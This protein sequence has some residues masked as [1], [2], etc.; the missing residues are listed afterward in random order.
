MT[1]ARPS[2]SAQNVALVRALLT[3]AGV[4]DD[5]YARQMLSPDRRRKAALFQLPGVRFRLPG[6]PGLAARTRFFDSF[7]DEALDGGV[8]QVVIVG[9]GYDSRAWR[10]ARPG[11]TFYE[12]DRPATQ[13]DKRAKAPAG[14]PVY[15]P[16]DVTDPHLSEA[17]RRA[18][19]QADRPTAFVLEGLI[20]YLVREDVAELLAR[21][22][23]FAA[24][25]SRM[26]VSFDNGFEKQRRFSR[27]ARAYYRRAGEPWRFRLAADDATSFLTDA[28]WTVTA[29]LTHRDLDREHLS[30]TRLAGALSR[31]DSTSFVAAA[32]T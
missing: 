6:V 15:I 19:L 13:D 11:V 9:A 16:L 14:G 3:R 30:R 21:L 28:G 27:Y 29:V 23:D 8:P 20:A 31:L 18:G 12:V 26:A 5:P 4:V 1:R 32:T 17:L 22:A 2:T 7:V 25:G 10:L 24:P